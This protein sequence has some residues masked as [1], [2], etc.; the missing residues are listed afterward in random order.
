MKKGTS[1]TM[2]KEKAR[3][4]ADSVTDYFCDL[5]KFERRSDILIN[6]TDEDRPSTEYVG[7]TYIHSPSH[8]YDI[9]LYV[10]PSSTEADILETVCHELIHVFTS[11]MKTFYEIFIGNE[12]ED[13]EPISLKIFIQGFEA[14]ARRLSLP[15]VELWNNKGAK[16]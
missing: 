1:N 15:L 3:K 7:V 10:E 14:I 4:L 12:D 2:T 8:Q 5:V 16:E 9:T 6:V 11:E 13:E